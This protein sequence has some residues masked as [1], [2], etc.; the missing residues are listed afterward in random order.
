MGNRLAQQI[1]FLVEADKLKHVV[2]RTPLVD[3]SRLENSA[4][5]SW[6]LALV[7][8]VLREY[9]PAGIDWLRVFEMVAVHVGCSRC[10]RTRTRRRQLVRELSGRHADSAPN[11]SDRIGHAERLASRARGDRFFLRRRHHSP[12]GELSRLH[13]E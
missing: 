4:E 5:H 6:H 12:I 13:L 1:A 2:R 3:S 9:G 7:I 8:M 11:G 10:F